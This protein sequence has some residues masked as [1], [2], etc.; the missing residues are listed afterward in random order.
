[1]DVRTATADR[2]SIVAAID[3]SRTRGGRRLGR[4]TVSI[5]LLVSSACPVVVA[6]AGDATIPTVDRAIR[7][8]AL[9]A[10]GPTATNVRARPSA[11]RSATTPI[12]ASM[13]LTRES[14]AD[15]VKL[16]PGYPA[17][18]I[19][20]ATLDALSDHEQ[21]G[22]P[23][24]MV[25]DEGGTGYRPEIGARAYAAQVWAT[26]FD[27]KARIHMLAEADLSKRSF[28]IHDTFAAAGTAPPKPW[29]WSPGKYD[30]RPF[31]RIPDPL[32]STGIHYD[33]AHAPA[34]VFDACMLMGFEHDQAKF[35]EYLTELKWTVGKTFF[36]MMENAPNYALGTKGIFNAQMGQQRAAAWALRNLDDLLLALETFV[37]NDEWLPWVANA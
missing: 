11:T 29:L 20:R 23:G 7:S 8:T 33:I 13:P 30:G 27:P 15:L 3:G 5:A 25:A 26:T 16:S 31:Q 14:Y 4:Y 22:T 1:M 2:R 34:F 37:P 17:D 35:D 9:A 28:P 36:D 10:A 12:G 32:R 18:A 24:E 6:S 21:P 19:P